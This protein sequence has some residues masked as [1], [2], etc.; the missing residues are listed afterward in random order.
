MKATVVQCLIELPDR[1]T[2]GDTY[3]VTG[4]ILILGLEADRILVAPHG[5]PADIAI[6]ETTATLFAR[7]RIEPA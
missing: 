1:A 6:G 2:I 4:E 3:P 7:L 5:R